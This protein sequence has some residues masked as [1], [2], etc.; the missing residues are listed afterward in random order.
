MRMINYPTFIFTEGFYFCVKPKTGEEI[1][2]TRVR[3]TK[4][5]SCKAS[6]MLTLCQYD[7]LLLYVYMRVTNHVLEFFFFF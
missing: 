1:L 4:P 5:K 3:F 7:M 6:G 2:G